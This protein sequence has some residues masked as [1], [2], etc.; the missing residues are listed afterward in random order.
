M[1]YEVCTVKEQ[2]ENYFKR[3][4]MILCICQLC[5]TSDMH[6][7]NMIAH[8]EYPAIID[9]ETLVQIPF[10]PVRPEASEADETVR[11]SVLTIGLL[12]FLA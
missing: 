5:H 2:A 3:L 12:P 11:M 8:G 6:Y 4:G 9:Y 1:S 7:E 10:Q